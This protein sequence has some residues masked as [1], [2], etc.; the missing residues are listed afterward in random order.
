MTTPDD[1]EYPA[2]LTI[3]QTTGRGHGL[4]GANTAL[5]PCFG[6]P[7]HGCVS[8]GLQNLFWLLR[9]TDR[10]WQKE[11][12][13]FVTSLCHEISNIRPVRARTDLAHQKPPQAHFAPKPEQ[14]QQH[15]QG[16][17]PLHQ[18]HFHV[19][20]PQ[21]RSFTCI[22]GAK[23]GSQF[24]REMLNPSCREGHLCCVPLSRAGILQTLPAGA[25]PPVPASPEPQSWLFILSPSRS[26]AWR[27]CLVCLALPHCCQGAGIAQGTAGTLLTLGCEGERQGKAPEGRK[28]REQ[29]AIKRTGTRYI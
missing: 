8:E 22:W 2:G 25:E 6:S 23:T 15:M 24:I 4:A 3:P 1:L 16:F 27:T 29:L 9:S 28:L 13:P 21:K 20:K 11:Q 10:F 26:R 7:A 19:W 5:L 12:K 18:C 17:F 14:S